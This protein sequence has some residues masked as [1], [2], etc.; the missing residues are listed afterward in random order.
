MYV[1][2]VRKCA[3]AADNPYVIPQ[4]PA[5]E[6]EIRETERRLAVPFPPEL[7][8]L[9]SEM[10]GDRWLLWPTRWIVQENLENREAFRDWVDLTQFLFFAGN[11]CGD[12]Y[13][14]RI[15]NG[16][17]SSSAIYLW[18][19]EDG[20]ARVVARNLAEMIRLYYEDQI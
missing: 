7:R 12:L 17:I 20:E 5:K 18:D 2:L 6:A 16:S 1:E 15:E 10:D 9:L 14:Y 11:G 19:H 4:R 8:K 3:K 13:G